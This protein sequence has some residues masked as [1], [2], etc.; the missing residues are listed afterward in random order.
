M[1]RLPYLNPS[2]LAPENQDLLKRPINLFRA[3]TH[4]PGGARAFYGLADYIRSNSPLDARLRELAIIQ[5]GYI[6]RSVY[7]YTH[8]V[9]LG[10]DFGVTHD[11]LINLAAYSAGK[12]HSLDDLSKAVLDAATQMTNGHAMSDKTWNF[13]SQQL[14]HEHLTDL[15]ITI[16]FYN[17]VVRFLETMQIDNEPEFQTFL[18][19]YPFAPL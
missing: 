15:V 10:L 13:L 6:T 18:A 1:S 4:S 3:M 8:H 5:V 11:D 9:K 7:E 2:D 12:P 14:S 17:G 16:S 19:K